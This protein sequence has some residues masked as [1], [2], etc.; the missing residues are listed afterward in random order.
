[1]GKVLKIETVSRQISVFKKK[2][3]R[4]ALCHGCFDLMHP[5]HI[6]H[7]QS[8]KKKCDILVVTITPDKYVN[9]G[10]YRP[11]FGE[12]DRAESIAA[13][14]CVDFVA[15][16]KWAS[17]VET[18]KLLRPDI[19]I[20]GQEYKLNKGKNMELQKDLM[21]ARSVGAKMAFTHEKIYS[22]T[23]LLNKHFIRK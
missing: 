4:V 11:V 7:L 18:I 5:G 12:K 8:A 19:Y 13:L 16:N 2:R 3:K 17:P 22:S 1:M 6:K 20:K 15:I 10:P 23:E 9:K 14:E 21:A